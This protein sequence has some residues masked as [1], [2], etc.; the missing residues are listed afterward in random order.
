MLNANNL[1]VDKTSD[2]K[3]CIKQEVCRYIDEF[4]QMNLKVKELQREAFSPI[5]IEVM[6]RNGVKDSRPTG[7]YSK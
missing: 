3:Q 1:F 2:C 4:K 7:S 6:C 5:T